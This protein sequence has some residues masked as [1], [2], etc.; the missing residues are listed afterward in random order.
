MKAVVGIPYA[1][2]VPNWDVGLQTTVNCDHDDIGNGYHAEID[3]SISIGH[4]VIGKLE[5]HVEFFSSVST[6]QNSDWIGTFDT[7]F[8]YQVNEN[9]IFDSG[10]YIGVTAAADDWHPWVGMTWRY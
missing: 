4:A 1:F 2:N 9:L 10:V 3:N 7:W 5:Y 6:E 8:T